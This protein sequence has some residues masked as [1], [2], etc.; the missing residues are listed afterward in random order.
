MRDWAISIGKGVPKSQRKS[1]QGAA[2]DGLYD[3][4]WWSGAIQQFE[5]P[6]EHWEKV[7]RDRDRA[8][9]EARK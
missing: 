8:E 4:P 5:T 3:R 2:R 7:R 1:M 6:Y 9:W